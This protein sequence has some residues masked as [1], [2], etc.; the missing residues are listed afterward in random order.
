M[1]TDLSLSPRPL[2]LQDPAAGAALPASPSSLWAAFPQRF[3]KP[4]ALRWQHPA[5]QTCGQLPWRQ[6][7]SV[8]VRA[9]RW[10]LG[11]LRGHVLGSRLPDTAV[12]RCLHQ[13]LCLH[14]MDTQGDGTRW[15]NALNG[16]KPQNLW[17]TLFQSWITMCY[18]ILKE[19]EH[20]W[21]LFFSWKP[22]FN[23]WTD[24][25]LFF[26]SSTSLALILMTCHQLQ[27]FECIKRQL[28]MS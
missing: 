9:P 1:L 22:F 27:K 7:R 26:L 10:G 8:G 23:F 12:P 18:E 25:G 5:R 28:N 24:N 13:S 19:E 16:E 3:H 21:S 14:L 4:D 15:E 17:Q 11:G 2:V 6:R 20:N